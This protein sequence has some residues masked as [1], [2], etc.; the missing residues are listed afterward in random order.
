MATT[1]EGKIKAKVSALLQQA[2]FTYY[3][4]PVPGYGGSSTLDYIGCRLGYFFGIETKAPGKKPTDR[5]DTIINQMK[6]AGARVFVIDGEPG[7]VQ[8]KA[9]L[10]IK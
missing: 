9:W 8:L 5:Q 10:D 6:A 2:T 1:P 4:M 3:H 7:L